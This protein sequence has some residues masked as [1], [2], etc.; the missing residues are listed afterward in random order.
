M[1]ETSNEKLKMEICFLKMFKGH[2]SPS[3]V[4]WL[5]RIEFIAKPSFAQRKK[6][7][8]MLHTECVRIGLIKVCIIALKLFQFTIQSLIDVIDDIDKFYFIYLTYI[9][10]SVFKM[11]KKIMQ[12]TLDIWTY[13]YFVNIS[14]TS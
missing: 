13:K 6:S 9:L 12:S 5:S 7:V 2:L 3:L 10:K 1:E 4:L 14:P 8:L 11:F